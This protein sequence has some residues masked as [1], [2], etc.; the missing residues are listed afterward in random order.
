MYDIFHEVDN[1]D[2]K[3]IFTIIRA[4]KRRTIGRE[5]IEHRFETVKMLGQYVV[6]FKYQGNLKS[7]NN[8][9]IATSL[10]LRCDTRSVVFSLCAQL[11]EINFKIC[12]KMLLFLK[13][14]SL[15]DNVL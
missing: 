14:Y 9:Y 5:K 1:N 11:Y 4:P 2:K 12:S 7:T 6:L 15:S 13:G 10:Y 8:V 3:G